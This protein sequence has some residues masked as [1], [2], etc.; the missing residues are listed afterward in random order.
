VRE[1]EHPKQL[2]Q[3]GLQSEGLFHEPKEAP[4]EQES[5]KGKR[6][7]SSPKRACHAGG[8][9]PLF[10]YEEPQKITMHFNYKIL[11]K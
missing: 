1:H 7:T 6:R 5:T 8:G 10:I 2:Q 11:S 9:A 3:G 4:G